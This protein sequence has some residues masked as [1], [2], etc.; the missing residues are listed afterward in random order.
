MTLSLEELRRRNVF[1]VATFYVVA[2]W[3]LL[4]A[5][6]LLFDTLGVPPWSLKLLLGLL[7]LGFPVAL[8]F[9]WIYELTPEGLKRE[10]E[11]VRDESITRVTA[12]KLD[13]LII[14]LLVMA[15]GL[16][17]ANFW[18]RRDTGLAT[19]PAHA[20]VTASETSATHADGPA[21]GDVVPPAAQ[22]SIAVLPFLNMSDDKANEYFS[23]GLTEE[24]LNVL[25]NVPGLRVI[26]RTSSF[27]YKGKD[28]KIADVA[29]DL[30][31]DHVLEGSVR[32]SGNRVRITTQ[33]IRAADSSHLWSETYDRNLDDIFAVQDEISN[34]VVGVLK[35]RLLPGARSLTGD[36]G[37]T[38]DA[39]AY[40]AFLRGRHLRSQGE[41]EVTLR[42]ALQ[43]LDEAIR[44]D[45]K[46][47]QAYAAKAFVLH[48]LASNAYVP[49]DEGFAQ[50]RQAAQ[51]ALELAPDLAEGHLALAIVQSIV[52]SN[53]RGA[54]ASMERALQLN[55]GSELVQRQYSALASSLGR[56]D[57]AIAAAQKAVALDPISASAQ[58]NLAGALFAARRYA[59]SEAAA[60]RVLAQ[61]PERAS[62]SAALGW[63][64]L[65]QGR[66]DEALQ[67]FD[68]E[69]VRW[70]RRNGRSLVFAMSGRTQ[71]ARRELQVFQ[72]ESGDY[73]ALQY[74]EAEAQLGNLD[75]A[76][77]WLET[78]RRVHD[79]GLTGL[80]YTD[81]TLDPLRGDPRF[82]RLMAE[83]G[84]DA[85]PPT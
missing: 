68:A 50:A 55:P 76:M 30:D 85:T 20:A 65:M 34:E 7:V 71:E 66:Y 54:V 18:S 16:L 27:A 74:A 53:V 24:L 26:A 70:A 28:V 22:A 47:A 82:Q 75:A 6:G 80:A 2:G 81:P 13:A 40:E 4:Q 29:R 79:P 45:P 25:A 44:L 69:P 17:L 62:A 23:D 21:S 64:L 15:I 61:Q 46:Y 41:A 3:V 51:R 11:V 77:R 58:L 59:E 36:V 19:D 12:R 83:L 73:A 9:A 56:H 31:V 42:A 60:R 67:A 49:F 5:G 84:F 43:E 78:A 39:R 37:G 8:V 38:H 48:P 10:H 52:D 35:V 63:A 72:K 33:L 1:R 14:A 32:K 57:A